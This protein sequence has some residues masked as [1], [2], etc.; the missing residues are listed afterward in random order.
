[1]SADTVTI[2]L[3]L[4]NAHARQTFAGALRGVAGVEL[5]NG[6]PVDL[7]VCELGQ[8]PEQELARL[9]KARLDGRV[10]EVFLAGSE[11]TPELLIQAIR[12]GVSEFLPLPARAEDLTEALRR[13]RERHRPQAAQAAAAPQARIIAVAG[14]KAGTGT[15]TVAVNLALELVRSGAGRVGLLDLR[16][17]RGE[18]PFFLDLECAY[19]WEEVVSN[20][21]RLDG[22]FLDSLITRHPSGLGLLPAPEDLAGGL[23]AAALE[24]L[25]SEMG[26]LFDVLVL[27][28]GPVGTRTH[29]LVEAADA[30]LLVLN[31]SLPCLARSRSFLDE[32]RRLGRGLESRVEL[33]A[34]RH[35]AESGIEP[36]EAAEVLGRKF[37]WLL[38]D[39]AKSALAALNQGRGLSEAAPKSRLA[40]SLRAMAKDLAPVT[41]R[42]VAAKGLSALLGRLRGR[43]ERLAPRAEGLGVA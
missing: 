5:Q 19:T 22:T 26:R 7:L 35:V 31:P 1:M 13:F 25:I 20:L 39:D 6:G 34:A 14:A 4:H 21:A 15:T 41:E 12:A 3:A 28:A 43:N 38:P 9:E 18:T 40:K 10:G 33:V 37:R 36:A 2:T 42:P 32:V 8:A 27:D 30:F 11:P 24:R 29:R 16:Q 17:P 23:D